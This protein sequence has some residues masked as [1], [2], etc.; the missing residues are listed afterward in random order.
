MDFLLL[1]LHTSTRSWNNGFSSIF[2]NLVWSRVSLIC[3]LAARAN[4]GQYWGDSLP[5][6]M[7][8]SVYW[9]F[10]NQRSP[11]AFWVITSQQGLFQTP[12]LLL[13]SKNYSNSYFQQFLRQSNK[14][15]LEILKVLF[16][17][18]F[19]PNICK[20]KFPKT[21]ERLLKK[22]FRTDFQKRWT[23]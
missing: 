6:P 3:Y 2:N 15:K 1:S 9:H 21:I 23:N 4:L 17:D 18:T 11:G 10:F 14:K 19:C 8:F 22:K 5:H 7:L 16:W 20:S 13:A 12:D